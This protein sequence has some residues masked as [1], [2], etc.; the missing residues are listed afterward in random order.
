MPPCSSARW[1]MLL[2]LQAG[3]SAGQLKFLQPI[4][5]QL[6]LLYNTSG[7]PELEQVGKEKTPKVGGPLGYQ[8]LTAISVGTDGNFFL[9]YTIFHLSG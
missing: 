2:K 5:S 4:Q 3:K 8:C 6:N 7:F 9:F 1:E